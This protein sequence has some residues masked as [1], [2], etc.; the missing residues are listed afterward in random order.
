MTTPPQMTGSLE[1]RLDKHFVRL[2]GR[3]EDWG[4]L[5]F[6][7]KV[8]PKYRRA[9]IVYPGGGTARHDDPNIQWISLTSDFTGMEILCL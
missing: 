6:Q 1:E 8:S 4:A 3:E 5:D 2:S 7:I 9:Q